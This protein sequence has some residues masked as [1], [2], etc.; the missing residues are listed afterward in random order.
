MA[1]YADREANLIV[2]AGA[3][4][5]DY[6]HRGRVSSERMEKFL[7]ALDRYDDENAPPLDLVPM[8]HGHRW[9]PE[10]IRNGIMRPPELE[11]T[12]VGRFTVT[13]RRGEG[14]CDEDP[15]R[16]C[17]VTWEKR[18]PFTALEQLLVEDPWLDDLALWIAATTTLGEPPM[19][20]DENGKRYL[21]MRVDGALLDEV[22]AVV[23]KG[24]R[25]SWVEDAMRAKLAGGVV[26]VGSDHAL[27]VDVGVVRESLTGETTGFVETTPTGLPAAQLEG[28]GDTGPPSTVS[29]VARAGRKKAATPKAP[30]KAKLDVKK[31]MR[32][33]HPA[34]QLGTA[35]RSPAT[36]LVVRECGVCGSNVIQR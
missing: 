8:P 28:G 17:T 12:A 26:D 11:T 18:T 29:P 22:D 3:V 35:K 1:E 27:T 9:M 34:D 33:Q 10:R 32:C 31:A 36:G 14:C 7:A 23:P 5:N 24:G 19:A 15:V 4:K 2:A 16:L 30:A 13:F 6:L 25:T 20:Y 21:A